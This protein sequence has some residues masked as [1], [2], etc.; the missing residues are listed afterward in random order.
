VLSTV[1]DFFVVLDMLSS[2]LGLPYVMVQDPLAH[3]VPG[4][5]D[6]VPYRV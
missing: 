1:E 4:L 2:V 5:K 3:V 6:I